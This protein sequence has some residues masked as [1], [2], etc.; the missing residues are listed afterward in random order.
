MFKVE[1][2]KTAKLMT[3][4]FTQH[5][6]PEELREA[7]P[8]VNALATGLPAG[9][10]LL[11]DMSGLT[12]MDPACVPYIK[13][14]MDLLNRRGIARVVRVIPDPHK[15]IGF[16]ILSLFHYRRGVHIVTCETLSEAKA[17]LAG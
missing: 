11:S 4:T 13:D 3:M 17:V 14:N 8:A 1:A 10:S 9:F 12:S 2:D 15:D 16:N 6:G 7:V 5:V